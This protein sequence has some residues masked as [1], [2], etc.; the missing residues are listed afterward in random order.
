MVC[1]FLNFQEQFGPGDGLVYVMVGG[2]GDD[3]LNVIVKLTL[4]REDNDL[5]LDGSSL[6][7]QSVQ[8]LPTVHLRHH[9]IQEDQVWLE[10]IYFL[11]TFL[12][13]TSRRY[14]I[15]LKR[16]KGLEDLKGFLAVI[17]DHD[18]TLVALFRCG[19]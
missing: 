11:Q 3:P 13:T 1:P 14:L 10:N 5:G 17:N 2:I 9:D 19:C 18:P 15:V 7:L 12:T 16:E 8:H 4:D 6:F